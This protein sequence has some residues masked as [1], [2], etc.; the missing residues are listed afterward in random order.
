M[1]TKI[2]Q[3]LEQTVTKQLCATHFCADRLRTFLDHAPRGTP[4]DR[5]LCFCMGRHLAS[6]EAIYE[7]HTLTKAAASDSLNE[8][9]FCCLTA[10]T[11]TAETAES[12]ILASSPFFASL[13][14]MYRAPHPAGRS[15]YH[16]RVTDIPCVHW[17]QQLVVTKWRQRRS[18]AYRKN[19]IITGMVL[20]KPDTCL[21]ATHIV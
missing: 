1:Y 21:D 3:H 15:E 17:L 19:S 5:N 14:I 9:S 13:Q 12:T 2:T 18:E 10:L 8:T 7:S 6:V 20:H 11:R 16:I 4:G